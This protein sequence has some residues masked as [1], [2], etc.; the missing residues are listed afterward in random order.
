M[1]TAFFEKG[2]AVQELYLPWEETPKK[3]K[4]QKNKP[5]AK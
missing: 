3:T 5:E 4:Q 2:G 1:H